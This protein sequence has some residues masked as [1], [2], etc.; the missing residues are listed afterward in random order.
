MPLFEG[1]TRPP[2][3]VDSETAALY[4]QILLRS[5]E[6]SAGEEPEDV[7]LVRAFAPLCSV[8]LASSQS[9]ST[10]GAIAFTRNWV[11]FA[12]AQR[13]GGEAAAHASVRVAIALGVGGGAR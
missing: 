11:T 3:I 12:E 7:R 9:R 5:L 8:R 10:A 4:K 13:L 1:F 2:T 6:V